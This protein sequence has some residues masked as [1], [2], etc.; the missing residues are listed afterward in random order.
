VQ[1]QFTLNDGSGVRIT[2]ARYYTPSGRSIQRPYE[3]GER[4][5]YYADLA[6]R[7][8]LAEGNNIEHTEDNPNDSA[9]EIY[10]TLDGRVVYGGGG[11]TPDY[12]IDND[13]VSHFTI[14]LVLKNIFV[15]FTDRW[16]SSHRS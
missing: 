5:K 1:R 11:I 15:E 4:E 12:I 3:K 6:Q 7:K 8:N 13:S 9:E 2:I 16:M 14:N 10:H